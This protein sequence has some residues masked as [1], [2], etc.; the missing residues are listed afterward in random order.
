MHARNSI[1]YEHKLILLNKVDS[2]VSQEFKCTKHLKSID[3][4]CHTCQ[5]QVCSICAYEYHISSNHDVFSLQQYVRIISLKHLNFRS[6]ILPI[7]KVINA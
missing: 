1:Y 6:L 3:S 2:K 7:L 4:F 5:L